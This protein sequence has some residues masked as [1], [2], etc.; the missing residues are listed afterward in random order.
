[1]HDDRTMRVHVI[2]VEKIAF[3]RWYET[4]MYRTLPPAAEPGMWLARL[5]VHS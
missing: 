1:M 4:D 5:A 2:D 3:D